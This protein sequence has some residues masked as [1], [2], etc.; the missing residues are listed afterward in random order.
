MVEAAAAA[1]SAATVDRPPVTTS[2]TAAATN[3][4]PAGSIALPI[5]GEPNVVS[6]NIL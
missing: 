6:V 5:C 3:R 2:V 1:G 4:L